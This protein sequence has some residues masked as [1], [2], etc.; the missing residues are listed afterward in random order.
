MQHTLKG[1]DLNKT[2]T[3]KGLDLNK[4]HTLSIV[5]YGY[6]VNIQFSYKNFKLS[7]FISQL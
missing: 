3:L 4:T 1:L 2:H 6:F 7:E 5:I